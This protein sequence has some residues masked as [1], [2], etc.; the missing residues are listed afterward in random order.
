MSAKEFDDRLRTLVYGLRFRPFV[1][2]LKDG[3]VIEIN[4]PSV[5]FGGGT[6]GFLSA[7]CELIGFSHKQVRRFRE[8]SRESAS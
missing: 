6:A 2:E 1:V 7:K 5:A 8:V 4:K 3:R